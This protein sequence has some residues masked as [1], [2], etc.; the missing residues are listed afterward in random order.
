MG[1]RMQKR[2]VAWVLT[3]TLVFGLFEGLPGANLAVSA[4]IH[5]GEAGDN[6]TWTLD[7]S[8]GVLTLDGTG[9]MW[10]WNWRW[11][12]RGPWDAHM[13][14]IT[15]VVIS[16]GITS[17][18]RSAFWRVT[19]LISVDIP[20]SVTTIESDAFAHATGLTTVY[21]PSVTYI[22][23]WAFDG[24]SSLTSATIRSRDATFGRGVFEDTH[25]DFA[26]HAFAGSTAEN[27][28]ID[29]EHNFVPLDGDGMNAPSAWAAEQVNIA[30]ADGLVPLSLRQ[31]Y[32][33]AITRAEFAAL[34]VAL[35]EHQR[36]EIAGR[37][38]FND[39]I[40]VN[41]QKAAHIGVVTGVGENR[42]DPRGA[43]TIEQSIVTIMRLFDMLN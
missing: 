15:G 41:V 7:T 31:R 9:P 29:N 28:A 25:P 14:S 11:G 34:A 20:D 16:N 39:T 33:Q 38:A 13:E 27:Y 43:Y 32:T 24:A 40:D 18:G 12:Y 42:F 2:G 4:Q 8:T 23:D 19:S 36:G 17:V 6:I 37:V 3:L 30:I 1:K 22:G 5:T 35:Y 10:D 21:M 26:I